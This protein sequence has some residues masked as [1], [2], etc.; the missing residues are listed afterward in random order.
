MSTLKMSKPQRR[1]STKR[2]QKKENMKKTMRR[3]REE[4]RKVAKACP[5]TAKGKQAG[6][7]EIQS[8]KAKRMEG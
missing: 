7:V 5:Q 6:V 4:K 3:E 1:K 2:R 8:V